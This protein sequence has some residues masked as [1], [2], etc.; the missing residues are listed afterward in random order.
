MLN[1]CCPFFDFTADEYSRIINSVRVRGVFLW[2]FDGSRGYCTELI[3]QVAFS[4][5]IRCYN[6]WQN[7]E[8]EL[9]RVRQ[10]HE[11]AR[12]QGRISQDRMGHSMSQVADVSTPPTS[13]PITLLYSS[14]V[15]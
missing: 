9:K 11:K 2:P 12:S 13:L 14:N 5:R 15:R 1:G 10:V 7:A 6:Q 4:S 3:L 8:S